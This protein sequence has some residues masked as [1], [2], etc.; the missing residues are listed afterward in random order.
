MRYHHLKQYLKKGGL[1]TLFLIQFFHWGTAQ[2]YDEIIKG[3]ESQLKEYALQDTHRVNLLN[4]LSYA[5]RRNDPMKIDSFARVALRLAEE[6]GYAKGKGIAYKNL[7][8]AE[9]KLSGSI[10]KIIEH[11]RKSIFWSKQANDYYTQVA[12]MNNLGLTY[13]AKFAYDESI[14]TLQKALDFH[15][16]NLPE[17]RLKLLL[18]GNLG[19]IYLKLE[20]YEQARYYYDE[21]TESAIRL[22]D[23]K[24]MILNT[25]TQSLLLFKLNEP[26]QAIKLIDQR[27]PKLKEIGDYQSIVKTQII[28]SNILLDKKEFQAARKVLN[29]AQATIKK[30]NLKVEQC[31]IFLNLSK[32]Y[33]AEQNIEEAKKIGNIALTCTEGN[34]D[35]HLQMRVAKH[36]IHVFHADKDA[37]GAAELF[38]RYNELQ[39]AYS[40]LQKQKAYVKTELAYKVK[41]KEAENALLLAKQRESEAT[42]QSQE[43]FNNSLLAIL[44]LSLFL[45]FFAAR[46]YFLKQ[47]QNKELDQK[48]LERTAALDESNKELMYSNKKL[49]QSNK[50]LEK[51]AYIASHD[52]K[53][54]LCTIVNFSKLLTKEVATSPNPESKLYL[55]HILDSGGRMM[56]LIE[57]VLEYSKLDKKEHELEMVDLNQLVGGV[58]IMLS[59]YI[60]ERNAQIQIVNPLPVIEGDKTQLLIVFKNFIENGLKYNTSEAPKIIIS[61]Q[62]AQDFRR[63]YFQDN[64]IGIEEEYHHKLFQMFS[65]LQNH[66]N[67]EGTGLGLSICKKIADSMGGEIGIDNEC[68]TGSSFYFG[69][70]NSLVLSE[71]V[72]QLSYAE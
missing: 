58:E 11:Y 49:A 9:Y 48:V 46:A 67:Y 18:L 70:P 55:K 26:E 1:L 3:L 64:G 15:K 5:Y 43:I 13:G 20:D 41:N 23:K 47:K 10:D 53:Q 24:T 32:I 28:L 14:E 57:D 52:L 44:L 34:P 8:S 60:E 22:H 7:G 30:F 45:V 6:L 61:S 50:E 63:V 38:V 66:Q 16:K 2:S 59:A 71:P 35:A 62:Q 39:K 42:I 40:D 17:N 27:L 54:P 21:L 19:D 31:G 68:K 33:F 65:R 69:V 37:V 4:D 36:M 56:N 72:K 29:E 12:C 51:F 25:E